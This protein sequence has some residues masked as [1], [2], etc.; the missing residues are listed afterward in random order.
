MS[1]QQEIDSARG[2]IKTDSYAMSIGEWMSL[3]ASNE[4]DIHP[5]FQRIYRWEEGQKSRFIES[6]LL[7]IPIP[8]IFVAQRENGVWDV[9]DGLQRLSTIFEFAGVLKNEEGETQPPLKLEKTKYLPTLEGKYWQLDSDPA[10]S[11]DVA[12]RLLIKRT[13]IGV[14]IILKESD[15]RS[16][17]EL[18]QRLNTGGSKLSEQEVRNCLLVMINKEFYRWLVSLATLQPFRDVVALTDR[19][20]KEKYDMEIALRFLVFRKLGE[21]E[22]QQIGDVGEF[23]TEEMIK[24]ATNPDYDL[25][26]EKRLF[27]QLFGFINTNLGQDA[28]KR[29]VAEDA[30]FKGGFLVSAFETVAIGM[31]YW[32]PNHVTEQQFAEKV[33]ALWGNTEFTENSG[34]GIRASTRIPKTVSLGRRLFRV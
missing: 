20:L 31:G 2:E 29:W 21:N 5:E 30:K 8:P 25:D 9:V 23:L 14:S 1:L 18:F 24:L 33:M 4:I 13:K 22:L 7:G 10:N 3:Y 28:F 16:K 11:F 32:L 26:G 15:S 17:F 27:E 12:Q 6:L 34:S 19:A